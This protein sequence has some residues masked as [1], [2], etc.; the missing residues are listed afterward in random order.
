MALLAEEPRDPADQLRLGQMLL[1]VNEPEHA[2]ELDNRLLANDRT[3]AAVW[4]QKGQ[5]LFLMEKYSD[6]EHAFANALDHNPKLDEARR[7]L[8]LV[9][10]ILRLDPSRQGLSRQERAQRTVQAFRASWKRLSTCADER[11]VS[12]TNPVTPTAKAPAETA[13]TSAA[14]PAA[15]PNQL[16]LLYTSGLQRQADLSE[17]ALRGNP[18]LLD[19]TMQY[20]FEVERTTA[21]AC[22]DMSITDQALLSLAQHENEGLK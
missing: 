13:A 5:A 17:E 9:R 2:V 8:A 3:N 6:A 10:E 18:D 11:G 4:L 16:Q 19:P 21:Q 15:P 14:L 12:L 1:Q 7:Q 20:V 22:P